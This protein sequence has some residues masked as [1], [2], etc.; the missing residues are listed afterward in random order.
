ML[1]HME[2]GYEE[3]HADLIKGR[4]SAWERY[5]L[6]YPGPGNSGQYYAID[7]RTAGRPRVNLTDDGR[8]LRQY[9]RYVRRGATRIG[10]GSADDR[11]SPVAFVNTDGRTVVVLKAA[12]SGTAAIRGLPPGRYGVSYA[13]GRQSAE[14]PDVQVSAG[15]ELQ[16]SIPAAGVLTIHAR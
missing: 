5:T 11:L 1:E 2:S 10:A 15:G 7:T 14:V 3:L 12:T 8:Y 9:F 4:V 16:A 13:I 6:A